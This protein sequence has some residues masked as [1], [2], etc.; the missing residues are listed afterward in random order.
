MAKQ[1]L[2][3]VGK[4]DYKADTNSENANAHSSMLKFC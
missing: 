1:V 3:K 4:I 2:K